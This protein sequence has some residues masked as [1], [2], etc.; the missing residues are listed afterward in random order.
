MGSSVPARKYIPTSKKVL[1][2]SDEQNTGSPWLAGALEPGSSGLNLSTQH[3]QRPS[4][5]T[6]RPLMA[7]PE[8]CVDCFLI[9][10]RTCGEQEERKSDQDCG[11]EETAAG[12]LG[13]A[14]GAQPAGKEAKRTAVE[15]GLAWESQQKHLR[16]SS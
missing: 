13:G 10:E 3:V 1:R 12:W 9:Q 2:A 6:G 4:Q 11:V 15:A 8:S 14:C 16:P 7:A 5:D